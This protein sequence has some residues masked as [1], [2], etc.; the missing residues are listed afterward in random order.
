MSESL[1]HLLCCASV[2][3]GQTGTV[4]CDGRQCTAFASHLH[5]HC[6]KEQSRCNKQDNQAKELHAEHNDAGAP[7]R[8]DAGKMAGTV[9][10][11]RRRADK[12]VRTALEMSIVSRSCALTIS[13]YLYREQRLQ[14]NG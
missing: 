3:P 14:L 11:L 13:P 1:T 8:E 12:D 6:D 2:S 10:R 7:C 5:L 4:A 9:G